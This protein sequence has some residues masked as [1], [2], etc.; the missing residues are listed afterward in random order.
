MRSGQKVSLIIVS[1][2]PG[3]GK[4]KLGDFLTKQLLN[5]QLSVK[6]FKFQDIRDNTKFSTQKFIQSML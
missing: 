5:E 3:S 6:L 2:I 4:S 1:G